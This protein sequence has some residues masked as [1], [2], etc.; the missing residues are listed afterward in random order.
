MAVD[1]YNIVLYLQ[2]VNFF[3]IVVPFLLI[4][5]IIFTLLEKTKIFGQASI[6]VNVL[7]SLLL[8]SLAI[9]NTTFIE[10]MNVYLGNFTIVVIIFAVT[11]LLI[12]FLSGPDFN[13]W[14]KIPAV[15]IAV[16]AIISLLA[17]SQYYSGE[18]IFGNF[19][20]FFYYLGPWIDNLIVLGLLFLAIFIPIMWAKKTRDSGKKDK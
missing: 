10:F 3:Q 1:F 6:G 16:I 14:I 5:V 19:G 17:K 12:L 15:I 13:N 7:V 4:F 11:L 8:S 2:G 20:F 9:V 18:D